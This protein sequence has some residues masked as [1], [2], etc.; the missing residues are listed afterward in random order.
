MKN[1]IILKRLTEKHELYQLE[2]DR[3][4][5]Q[6]NSTLLIAA[7]TILAVSVI[8]GE[9]SPLQ[10]SISCYMS[11]LNRLTIGINALCILLLGIS[12][13]G[14][15]LRAANLRD[16]LREK[17]GDIQALSDEVPGV[18]LKTSNLWG[19]LICERVAYVSFV[20]LIACLTAVGLLK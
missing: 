19:F 12:L 1:E 14:Y 7:S 8:I 11:A 13:F 17:L 9:A 4:S 3:V 6:V 10:G 20:L 18:V 2:S 16:A 15:A 5:F